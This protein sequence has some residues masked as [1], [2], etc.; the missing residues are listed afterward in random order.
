[1]TGE[2]RT[3]GRYAVIE[4]VGRGGMG[5]VYRA[6]DEVLDREVAIKVMKV[7]FAS[8]PGAR[9]RFGREARAVAKLQHRNIVTIHELGEVD[10]MPYIVM[11][12][13]GGTDL[14]VLMRG[15]APPDVVQSLDVMTEL[16]T[17]LA[18]AHE[19]GIVHCDIKPANVRV[20][21]DG[22]V[23]LLDFGIAKLKVGGSTQR[24]SIMGSVHYMAPEQISGDRIDGRADLFA[25]G[26]LLYELLSH[27]KP[28]D[29]SV[30]T[31]IFH[32][33]LS[34]EP[35][36]VRDL[37]PG[38][39]ALLCD[40]VDR[41]LQKEPDRRYSRASEMASDLQIARSLLQAP[42]V[43]LPI[44]SDSLP[45]L[46]VDRPAADAVSLE[47]AAPV[48]GSPVDLPLR[49]AEPRTPGSSEVS[50]R[51][52]VPSK[53]SAVVL[54]SVIGLAVVA[55]GYA[56]YTIGGRTPPTEPSAATTTQPAAVAP[57]PVPADRPTASVPTAPA[58]PVAAATPASVPV[59]DAV[60]T[61]ATSPA[62]P[63]PVAP[64]RPARPITIT[65]DYAFEVLLGNTVISAAASE[66]TLKLPAGRTT[67]RLRNREYFLGQN[68][69]VE[70]G[71]R[72]DQE[73]TAPPL[74]T[75]SIFSAREV[76][77]LSIDGADAGFPPL[78]AQRVATGTHRISQ[79]CPDGTEDVRTVTI[80]AGTPQT[81]TLRPR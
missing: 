1:M 46:V 18:Y 50:V 76:C 40:I 2:P 56:L 81:V 27:R 74:A 23:K 51:I 55:L 12:F 35:A 42:P 31:E 24:G 70:V 47:K 33:I 25:A 44:S 66:H 63:A 58:A 34:R 62:A 22:T 71:G 14:E 32:Q 80:E 30:P 21:D 65:G 19:R 17:G 54:V 69:S 77:P 48:A 57:A 16:C 49:A 13:L 75:V 43:T 26:V 72:Q 64:P 73:L 61:P 4:R 11:E 45:T 36:P 37:V 59:P 3:I 20:F 8:E 29:G 53:K 38:L 5:V 7:D 9:K 78:A 52:T 15:D 41:A 67:L 28:F 68:L 39:P 10:D 79:K 60:P 6:R